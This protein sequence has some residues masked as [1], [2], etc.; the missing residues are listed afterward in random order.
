LKAPEIKALLDRG[1]R[2]TVNSDDPAYFPGY[3]LENLLAV[4]EQVG[5]TA[6]EIV[7]LERN[8]FTIAWLDDADRTGY[9]R[10]LE[11]AAAAG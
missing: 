9:L 11:A 6:E 7:Q 2:A 4:Q 5:L 1:I 8:A 3:V 10:D